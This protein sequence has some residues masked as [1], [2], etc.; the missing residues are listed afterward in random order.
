MAQA[1]NHSL[2]Y[3]EEAMLDTLSRLRE[4]GIESV[5]AGSTSERAYAPVV[6]NVQGIRLAFLSYTDIPSPA[7]KAAEESPGVAWIDAERIATDIATAK[8]T[9]DTVAVFFH[10]GIE[11]SL[12]VTEA[13]R[14]QA[15]AAIDAGAT[16]VLGSHPH[17]LQEVEE[18]EGGIIAY[19]LGNF[20]FDGFDE[21]PQANDSAILRIELSPFG[22]VGWN[23]VPVRIV[24]GW[25]T[26]VE[27]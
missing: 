21:E 7:W 25:P 2:D 15:H 3:G 12:V 16:L 5:G 17:V 8:Q 10:F 23:L 13:Q 18:Y 20:A 4:A 27:R 14:E 19:S 26:L 9:A 1:N 6:L 24:G 11:G 22:V